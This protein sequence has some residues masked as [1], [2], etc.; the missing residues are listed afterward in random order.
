MDMI[1]AVNQGSWKALIV[2]AESTRVISAC[3]RMYDIM[4]ENITVVEKIDIARQP[5]PN[6]EAIYFLTP[7]PESVEALINDFKRKEKDRPYMYA[8]VHLFFTSKLPDSEFQKISSAAVASKIKTF[9]ELNLEFIAYESQAFHLDMPNSMV[10]FYSGDKSAPAVQVKAVDKL[11]TLCATLNEYPIIRYSQA[12]ALPVQFARALQTRLD[13]LART[14]EGWS[15]NEDRATL[16]IVD[17][18]VDPLAPLLHE[19]TYQAMV[20]DLLEIENDIY[21]YNYT[22]NSG[23]Q[24]KDVILGEAD[25]LWPSLR[26]MHIADAINTVIDNFNDFLKS[27]KATKLTNGKQIESLK[28]MG[29]AMR[30]MPQYTEMLSKYSLHIHMANAAMEVFNK[31]RLETIAHLEQDMATG[32]DAEG[33]AVKNV[34]TSLPPILSDPEVSKEEKLRLLM[35][36]VISQGGLKDQDRKRL[37]DLAK[38]S[39]PEQKAIA[40]LYHLGVAI[41]KTVTKKAKKETKKKKKRGDVSYEL[42]RYVPTV[43]EI[44]VQLAEDSL[45]GAD[46]PFIRDDPGVSSGSRSSASVPAPVKQSLK[47][48]ATKH[49]WAADK[50]KK[51]EENKPQFVGPRIILFVLGGMT[52]SEMRSAYEVTAQSQRQVLIGSSHIITP[53]KF[54]EDLSKLEPAN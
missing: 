7:K 36:Y 32:E 4:E 34:I 35:I 24:K 11:V 1:R 5:L 48:G 17:R 9:R 6:L 44:L 23:A 13:T 8:A 53:H 49:R 12:G 47:G 2:D 50:G 43:K 40:N 3:C 21:K 25:V 39:V 38:I 30:A 46:F 10:V 16:L 26:H 41:N 52:Y 51:K 54:L 18:G 28:D 42:S 27:N 22:S 31:R 14:A 15:P 20:Y 33:K 19:F 29:E 45:S 37:M